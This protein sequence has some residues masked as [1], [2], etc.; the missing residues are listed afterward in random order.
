MLIA[1]AALAGVLAVLLEGHPP[2]GSNDPHHTRIAI[3]GGIAA[4]LCLVALWRLREVA[5]D[6]AGWFDA[7]FWYALAVLA[8]VA[9]VAVGFSG[10]S[11]PIA[12][13]G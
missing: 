3:T 4:L 6:C 10:G 9:L 13:G 8:L 12:L 5:R 7:G 2:V 11:G 1:W